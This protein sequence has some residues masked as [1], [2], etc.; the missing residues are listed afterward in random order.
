MNAND[1]GNSRQIENLHSTIEKLQQENERLE[2][3]ARQ[4]DSANKAKSDFLAMISHEIRTPM[5]G[6]IGLTELLLGTRLNSKQQRY[7][8]LILTSARNL[9]TLINSLLDFSKI[10]AEM[11]ELDIVEFNL[12]LMVGEL[13][14]LYN[15]ATE[16]KEVEVHAEIGPQIADL[17]EGDS[18]RI[19]QILVN[20]LGNA[21]KFTEEG[22]VTLKIT[23]EDRNDPQG[24]ML[25]FE[26]IDSGPGIAR[27][28]LDRLFKPFTQL[29]STSTRRY[30]GTGLG[31]SICQKLVELMGGEIGV[32]S[33][34]DQGSTFWFRI[35]LKPVATPKVRDESTG[36]SAREWG[37]PQQREA[38]SEEPPGTAG[39]PVIMVVDDDETNRFVMEMVLLKA[40][41]HVLS[42]K[43]GKE[44]LE[45]YTEN[46]PDMILMDCQM[47]IMDGFEACERIHSKAGELGRAK[48]CIIALT[49]DATQTTRQRCREVGMSDYLTKPLEF[50][51]LQSVIGNWLP[52]ADMH[53]APSS[54]VAEDS[55]GLA[56]TKEDREQGPSIDIRVID[57]LKKNMGDI[58][59]VIN[60]FL[61][62]LPERLA[63]LRE[64]VDKEDAE[65]IRRIAHILKGSSSQFGA[66]RMSA[67]CFEAENM[68]KTKRLDTIERQYEK[69]EQAA[70]Q[71]TKF[72]RDELDKK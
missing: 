52:W 44:A 11:M 58:N 17:Y 24:D 18:Y 3:L 72:L 2:E 32:E 19:R 65:E 33:V 10:E 41:A 54:R 29:D 48:P 51:R 56:Y 61:N 25:R 45:L 26:V 38:I 14:T 55:E 64:A 34:L 31:L 15:A 27:D 70:E 22:V 12:K 71:L 47:P 5:N 39:A 59:L 40:G 20:L 53:V 68:G 9:L 7:A 8:G 1:Q 46:P 23:V 28:K 69:I 50:S 35:P 66:V 63:V 30:G 36:S 57:R 37:G 13:M 4:A 6:V 62:S 49:A 67:V 16:R 60:V 42:V 43:N 21:I